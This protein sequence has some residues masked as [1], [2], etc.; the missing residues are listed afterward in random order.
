VK[1]HT[2]EE[3]TQN[4]ADTLRT[5]ASAL[6]GEVITIPEKAHRHTIEAALTARALF[7]A[8]RAAEPDA[9]DTDLK[10][11]AATLQEAASA[12]EEDLITAKNRRHKA[13][14]NCKRIT[15]HLVAYSKSDPAD[16]L[17]KY[18]VPDGMEEEWEAQT[19]T[20][21]FKSSIPSGTNSF[22]FKSEYIREQA[23]AFFV[24]EKDAKAK[25]KVD[26]HRRKLHDVWE[27]KQ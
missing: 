3:A 9:S 11:A 13:D 21:S 19:S 25:I 14:Q 15:L 10:T 2:I 5:A 17:Q 26:Q 22:A 27:N 6:L 18:E 8:L 1:R 16:I 12:L 20:A 24:S 7:D 4:E 23:K